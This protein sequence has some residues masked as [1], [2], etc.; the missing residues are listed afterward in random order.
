MQDSRMQACPESS[1]KLRRKIS[2]CHKTWNKNGKARNNLLNYILNKYLPW[3]N[4]AHNKYL[5]FIKYK[6]AHFEVIF[7][8]I[9]FRKFLSVAYINHNVP[10]S[11]IILTTLHLCITAFFLRANVPLLIITSTTQ[12]RQR[13]W[14]NLSYPLLR[15]VLGRV[16]KGNTWVHTQHKQTNANA[17]APY[18][19][20]TYNH[21]RRQ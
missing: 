9:H 12:F 20:P 4:V 11:N 19:A 18:M 16:E 3:K 2:R 6:F 13:L 7:F 5:I 8:Y 15:C 1:L 17:S 10:T 21:T 14:M